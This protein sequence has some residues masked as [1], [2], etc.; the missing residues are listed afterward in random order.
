MM[1][2]RD[3][4]CV[5]ETTWTGDMCIRI[6]VGCM[7]CLLEWVHECKH[8]SEFLEICWPTHACRHITNFAWFI[9]CGK[10]THFLSLRKIRAWAGPQGC[11]QYD[12]IVW[13]ELPWRDVCAHLALKYC[14]VK[15]WVV[16]WTPMLSCWWWT[17]YGSYMWLYVFPMSEE[18]TNF[19]IWG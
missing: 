16:M 12:S 6:S 13:S 14:L 4:W 3:T 17:Y 10:I 18:Y 15:W 9:N 11:S 7:A 8:A 19:I 1:R 2:A 5:T